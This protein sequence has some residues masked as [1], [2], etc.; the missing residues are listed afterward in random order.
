VSV[1]IVVTPSKCVSDPSTVAPGVVNFTVS[2]KNAPAVTEVE[3]RQADGYLL[4]EQPNLAPGVLGGMTADLGNG[5]YE[6]YCPGANQTTVTFTV[7]G[8]SK[9]PNWKSNPKLVRAVAL[10]SQWMAREYTALAT[11]TAAFATAVEAGNLSQ[12][13]TLYGP[14]RVDFE[15]VESASEGY[16]SLYPDIDGQIEN[17]GNPSLFQGFHEIEESMWVGDTLAGQATYAVQLVS[18]VDLLQK[19]AS[20]AMF[21]PAQIGDFAA[22]QLEEANN[23]L[24]TGSEER[25]S[26]LELEDLKG[27]LGSAVEAVT[28]LS[29]A[30][31][32][33]DPSLLRRL[34]ATMKTATSALAHCAQSPGSADTGYESYTEVPL[35]EREV[36]AQDMLNMAS[37]MSEATQLVA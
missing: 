19:L 1:D 22:A 17:F 15:S 26:N 10:F 8:A 29:P 12:A 36:L 20:T 30:L 32:G 31:S 11:D 7:T 5:T 2:N 21:Q 4:A 24:V 37:P 6:I 18:N 28:V 13:E 3:L 33:D 35:S 25:Y 34:D 27:N 14:A 9:G 16:G 23:Y